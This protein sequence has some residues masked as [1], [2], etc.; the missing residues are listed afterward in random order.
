MGLQVN[1]VEAS[2]G[3]KAKPGPK[4]KAG[5]TETPARTNF[6]IVTYLSHVCNN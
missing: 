4:P 2:R 5:R 6:S 3:L 1:R